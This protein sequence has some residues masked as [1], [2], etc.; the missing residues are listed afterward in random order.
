MTSGSGGQV[1]DHVLE[2]LDELGVQHRQLFRY[3]F[4]DLGD[5]LVACALAIA[6]QLHGNV[7][8]VGLGH[9]GEAELKAG[10]S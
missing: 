4:A 5:H 7:A 10:A 6:L 2:E 1:A 9:G 8:R 3:F